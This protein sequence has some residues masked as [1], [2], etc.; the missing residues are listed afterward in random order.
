MA[1]EAARAT[2]P[3]RQALIKALAEIETEST[4]RTSLCQPGAAFALGLL[5]EA[6]DAQPGCTVE[7]IAFALLDPADPSALEIVNAQLKATRAE[8]AEAGRDYNKVLAA[9]LRERDQLLQ[10]NAKLYEALEELVEAP[11]RSPEHEDR[12]QAVLRDVKAELASWS[13]RG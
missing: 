13:S 5:A 11:L 8:Y 12:A 3:T 7:D 9:Q 10:A 1:D 6:V 2:R 4:S